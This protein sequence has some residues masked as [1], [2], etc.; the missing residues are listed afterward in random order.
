MG[1]GAG[2]SMLAGFAII[3]GIPFPVWLYYY[4][5]KFRQ[6]SPLTRDRDVK[7]TDSI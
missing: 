3:L 2:N 6:R 4:G 7:L 1:I 5:E